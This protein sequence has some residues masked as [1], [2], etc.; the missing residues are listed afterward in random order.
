MKEFVAENITRCS[1][2]DCKNKS[3][4][5]RFAQN[6]LDIARGIHPKSVVNFNAADCGKIIK[7]H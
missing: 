3:I 5:K 4:C 1:N 6:Q 7:F 2:S